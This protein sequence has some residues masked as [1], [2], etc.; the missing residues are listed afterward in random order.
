MKV[1]DKQQSINTKSIWLDYMS[2]STFYVYH[3]THWNELLSCLS[4][5]ENYIKKSPNIKEKI[6]REKTINENIV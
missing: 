6:K 3:N 5:K 4:D 2:K 1:S